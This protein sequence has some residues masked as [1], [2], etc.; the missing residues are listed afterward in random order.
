V[1]HCGAALWTRTRNLTI[2]DR[3]L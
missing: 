3:V 2:I 1:L